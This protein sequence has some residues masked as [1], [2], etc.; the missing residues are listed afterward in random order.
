MAN[1]IG[2]MLAVAAS[3]NGI[4]IHGDYRA[5]SDSNLWRN[6]RDII[7]IGLLPKLRCDDP[8]SHSAACSVN[9]AIDRYIVGDFYGSYGAFSVAENDTSLNTR[10][11]A[12]VGMALSICRV[13]A[14]FRARQLWQEVQRSCASYTRYPKDIQSVWRVL[15]EAGLRSLQHPCWP[16][17]HETFWSS[18]ISDG[19]YSPDGV[20]NVDANAWLQAVE[21]PV[22]MWDYSD[23]ATHQPT[24]YAVVH[25]TDGPVLELGLGAYSTPLIHK[26]LENSERDIVSVDNDQERIRRFANLYSTSSHSFVFSDQSI[27]RMSEHIIRI[28]GGAKWSVVFVDHDNQ[29]SRDSRLIS[30][31]LMAPFAKFLV[32]HD[33]QP[34]LQIPGFPTN[35]FAYSEVYADGS[36]LVVS[37]S[38]DCHFDLDGLKLSV[39]MT[40]HVQSLDITAF[41]V[42]SR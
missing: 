5:L 6:H 13:D 7:T 25:A 30:L 17:P 34:L 18:D 42:T 16:L 9:D 41:K 27:D 19:S 31:L 39:P 35:Y 3:I 32:I 14:V 28:S 8:K 22:Y 24:L 33:V 15:A 23:W 36:V 38:T 10:C 4:L 29:S 26:W 21:R 12:L 20:V 11:T 1:G 37:N 2:R 40:G